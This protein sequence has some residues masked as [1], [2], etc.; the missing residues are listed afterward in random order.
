MWAVGSSEEFAEAAWTER[1]LAEAGAGVADAEDHR[2]CGADGGD[3]DGLVGVEGG[4]VLHRVEEDLAE[5]LQ[6]IL[7][8]VFGELGAELFRE[9][10]EAIGGDDAAVD[11]DGDPAGAGGEDFDVV[12]DLLSEAACLARLAISWV[13]KGGVKQAKTRAR[14]AAMTLSGVLWCARTMHFRPGR[15]ERISSSSA[16]FSSMS[17][18]ALVMTTPKARMR[19]RFR[20]SALP[21][22]YSMGKLAAKRESPISRLTG[23]W[24]PM[25]RTRLILCSEDRGTS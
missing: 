18:S 7:L 21:A 6:E 2:P 24:L 9:G 12:A 1:F 25:M 11:A 23:V 17:L 14:R 10:E 5:G 15:M 8:G 16:R 3:L 20:A 22:E 19:R 13:S 4:A